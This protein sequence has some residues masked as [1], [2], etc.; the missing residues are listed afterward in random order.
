MES[1]KIR[2]FLEEFGKL[3]EEAKRAVSWMFHNIELLD[4]LCEGEKLTEE[5]GSEYKKKALNNKDYIMLIITLYKQE[6][7]RLNEET[8]NE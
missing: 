8:Q 4:K 1:S 3:D 7:D 6:K 2:L 5:Q